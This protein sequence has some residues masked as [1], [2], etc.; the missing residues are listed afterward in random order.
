MICWPLWVVAPLLPSHWMSLSMTANFL[1]LHWVH[2]TWRK[3]ETMTIFWM[4]WLWTT[5]IG[6]MRLHHLQTRISKMDK[7][8][9]F[10]TVLQRYLTMYRSVFQLL[11]GWISNILRGEFWIQMNL[12]EAIWMREKILEVCNGQ[13]FLCKIWLIPLLSTQ[14]ECELPAVGRLPII[15]HWTSFS[16]SWRYSVLLKDGP[17]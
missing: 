15:L 13:I 1:I 12:P 7:D 16:V 4:I 14:D 8:H 5:P 17:T 2:H 9:V 3:M 11:V 10:A 6:K